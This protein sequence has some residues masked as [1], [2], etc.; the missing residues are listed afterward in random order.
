[1]FHFIRLPLILIEGVSYEEFEKKC[2]I[3]NASK[4]WEFQDGVVIIFEL[5]NRD[6]EFAHRTFS[7]QFERQDPQDTVDSAGSSSMYFSVCLWMYIIIPNSIYLTLLYLACHAT[8]GR[9][10]RG[11]SKQPDDSFVPRLLPNPAQ[12][13]CDTQVLFFEL[14]YWKYKDQSESIVAYRV[15]LGLPLSLR[16][17]IQK[18]F[19]E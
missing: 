6:H 16:W 10:T 19:Q 18:V 3:A 5:P 7:K 17:L 15:T 13:P 12:N 1:M 11:S 14:Y 2:E 4:Y 9:I 8:P